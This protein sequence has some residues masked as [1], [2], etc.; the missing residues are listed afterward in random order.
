MEEDFDCEQRID[1]SHVPQFESRLGVK[2]TLTAV[3]GLILGA[4]LLGNSVTIRVCTV[5]RQRGYLQA[6]VSRH[7]VSLA[8]SDL[9]L[10]LLGL[11]VELVW[12]VWL[13]FSSSP[14]DLACKLY[15]FLLETCSYATILHV[16]T[17][18]LE[19]Y[20]AICHPFRFQA[21]SASRASSLLIALAWLSS[22]CVATP[23][24]FTMGSEYP[25]TPAVGSESHC[26]TTTQ[27]PKTTTSTCTGHNATLCRTSYSQPA[28]N[29]TLCSSLASRW[30]AFRAS[31]FS[32]FCVYMLVLISVAFMCR[33]MM[34]TLMDSK[35]GTVS[36]K[37]QAGSTEMTKSTSLEAKGARKQTIIFLGMIVAS[38]A[39]CWMPNQ[40]L[41]IMAASVPKHEW[42]VSYFRTYITLLPVADT[43][44]Y[45]SSVLNPILYNISSKQFREVF[46]QVL[47]CHLTIEH[48]NK[49]KFLR[50]QLNSA[51][52]STNHRRPLMLTSFRQSHSAN[53]APENSF[54]TFQGDTDPNHTLTRIVLDSHDI[55]PTDPVVERSHNG[56]CESEI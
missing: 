16:A 53:R 20:T 5:L 36:V 12:G 45:L 7:M 50:V 17:L 40:I 52:S 6:P 39:L 32:A 13:P 14:G 49:A 27:S 23:L 55:E 1:A 30:P 8:C 35:K 9:L 41:R 22:L 44:F 21:L 29:I 34:L 3:Y 18:S 26:Y 43:F 25:L 24:L 31:V 54:T 48:A 46:L 42:T 2:V 33:K 4:G 51:K 15:C 11:P 28:T 56:L 37:G 19:R 47:R 10:L 38:L